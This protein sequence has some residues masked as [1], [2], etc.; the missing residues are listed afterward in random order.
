M[1]TIAFKKVEYGYHGKNGVF[2]DHTERTYFKTYSRKLF[3]K[4]FFVIQGTCLSS[5]ECADNS[6]TVDGNC[7]SGKVKIYFVCKFKI[8]NFC[9]FI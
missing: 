9:I 1:T 7:A 6:G 4:R 5:T 8:I 3:D 2:S